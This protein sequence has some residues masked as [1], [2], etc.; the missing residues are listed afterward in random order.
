ML[1]AVSLAYI[2]YSLYNTIGDIELLN[3][4][5]QMQGNVILFLLLA[6]TATFS[7][8][9][10][11][12]LNLEFLSNKKLRTIETFNIFLKAGFSRYLPGNIM[13]YVARNLYAEQIGIT[14]TKMATGSML[15][16][17]L[18]TFTT[19][20]LALAFGGSQLF[21]L[22][23]EYIPVVMFT[24]IIAVL[25][26]FACIAMVILRKTKHCERIRSNFAEQFRDIK[27]SSFLVFSAKMFGLVTYNH[28]IIG[29][30]FWLMLSASSGITDIN[31]FMVVSACIVAWF[32]GFIT[33]VA[34]AGIGVK[35][36][37]LS[38]FLIDTFGGYVLICA[39]LL[40]VVL[41]LAELSTF[42]IV[43]LI[44]S[45]VVWEKS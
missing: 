30:T 12:K 32:V 2:A 38:L 40:R 29:I 19:F 31:F 20:V 6:V 33:P 17:I 35:E 13:Q 3:I 43:A 4:F 5:R 16:I 1:V 44:N 34:P 28:I 45:Q 23:V 10:A 41:M 7:I 25:L 8:G 22:I 9:F 15:E 37:V 18:I 39:I 42:C 24:I 27:A 36:A 21:S 26:V 14:Q 11:W